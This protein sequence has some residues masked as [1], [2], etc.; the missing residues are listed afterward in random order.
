MSRVD[1]GAEVAAARGTN[2]ISLKQGDSVMRRNR[3]H[4]IAAALGAGIILSA[5]ASAN[6]RTTTVE[7]G[8]DV[9]STADVVPVTPT[10]NASIPVGATLTATLDQALGTKV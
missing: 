4:G 8:G 5:C 3:V 9:A 2:V 10:N 1:V 6:Q 7:S